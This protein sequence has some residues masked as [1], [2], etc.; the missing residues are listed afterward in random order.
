MNNNIGNHEMSTLRNPGIED[1]GG[2]EITFIPLEDKSFASSVFF[3]YVRIKWD[4]IARTPTNFILI[5]FNFF[6]LT[7][8]Y[9]FNKIRI[10]N[11]ITRFT[12][13]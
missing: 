11:N 12:A 6:D 10:S 13:R 8:V 2:S 3:W 1:S 5:N 7:T 4:A 9:S